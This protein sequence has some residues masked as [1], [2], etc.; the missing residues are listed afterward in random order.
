MQAVKFDFKK[1]KKYTLW[2]SGDCEPTQTQAQ[3]HAYKH[4]ITYTQILWYRY[5]LRVGA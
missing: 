1:D 5:V 2:N 4:T 3:T